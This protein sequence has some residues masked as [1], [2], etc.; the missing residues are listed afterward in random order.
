MK[1]SYAVQVEFIG[2]WKPV[3][4][5]SSERSA[6]TEIKRCLKRDDFF[7]APASSYRVK[8]EIK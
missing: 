1:Q 3:S 8:K 4:Y 2:G 7:G 6:K 5:H